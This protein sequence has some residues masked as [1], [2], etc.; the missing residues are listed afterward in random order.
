MAKK[1]RQDV[2]LVLLGV[3]SSFGIWSAMNTSPVGT[4]EFGTLRPDVTWT[5][6]GLSLV[7]ILG[8][9]AGVGLVYGKRG[10][11]AAIA[12]GVSGAALFGWY[13]YLMTSNAKEVS[14]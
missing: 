7:I 6:M 11:A 14:A 9:A 1:I 10:Q 8:M 3:G 12:T 5:S 2:G 13:A 4:V